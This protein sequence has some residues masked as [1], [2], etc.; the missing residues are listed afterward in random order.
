MRRLAFPIVLLILASLACNLTRD[1]IRPSPLPPTFTPDY[2]ATA[3]AQLPTATSTLIPTPSVTPTA[4]I[5]AT[6]QPSATPTITLTPLPTSTPLATPFFASDN[7]TFVD[8][9]ASLQGGLDRAW[10]A[11]T[12]TDNPVVARED[13]ATPT[14]E[15]VQKVYFAQPDGGQR[16]LV[17]ELPLSTDNRIYWSPTGLHVA[18]FLEA[19]ADISGLYLLNLQTGR[20]IRVYQSQNLQPRQIPG[21][22]PVWSPDGT[23]LAFA[24]P[25]AYATDIFIINADGTG[26]TNLT[27]HD[28]Y[29]FWPAWS[30]DGRRLAFVSDRAVCPTWVPNLPGSCDRPDA[31]PPISGNLYVYNFDTTRVEKITDHVL[32]APPVWINESLVSVS[33]GSLD[34]FSDVSELWVYDVTAGSTWQLTAPNSGLYAA[35]TWKKDAQQVIFQRIT[36]NSEIVLADRFGSILNVTTAYTFIRFGMAADWSPDGRYVALAGTNGQCPYGL[37]VLNSNFQA[38][39]E[40]PENLLACNPR[41]NPTGNYLAY[42][43]IRLAP[44]TDGRLDV[45][46]AEADGQRPRNFTIDLDG[47]I[48]ILGWV[49]PTFRE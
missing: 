20:S 21:H 1:P 6:P 15:P 34:P 43:G 41:Y 3:L 5:T 14:T 29:D 48:R 23:R 8:V 12:V 35:P 32:N 10:L 19:D 22:Q 13:E 49:G 47:L 17:M 40:A 25:T 42:E 36:Q 2:T 46:I 37:I 7:V 24:L 9:P 27:N 45:Y 11:Y 18:Y 16:V 28:A 4:T 31:T 39:Y 30:A 26:F 38:A 44:G 33:I